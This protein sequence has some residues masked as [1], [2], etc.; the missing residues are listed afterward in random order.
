MIMYRRLTLIPLGVLVVIVYVAMQYIGF[1][2]LQLRPIDHT[3]LISNDAMLKANISIS[4]HG[5]YVYIAWYDHANG[6]IVLASS[7]DG[8][9]TYK[10]NTIEH[11]DNAVINGVVTKGSSVYIVWQSEVDGRYDVFLSRSSDGISFNTTNISNNRGDSTFPVMDVEGNMVY[12]AWIDSTDGDTDVLLRIS[13]DGGYTFS[14]TV[15]ISDNRGDSESVAVDAEG[16]SVYIAWHDN[17]DGTFKVMLR[18]SHDYGSTF[19][20]TIVLSDPSMDSGFV[21]M[22]AEGKDVYVA[23]MSDTGYESNSIY[24]RIS[25]DNGHSFNKAV[26]ISSDGI[27]VPLLTSDG[28]FIGLTYIDGR[29]LIFATI[30]SY[31]VVS[32]HDIGIDTDANAITKLVVDIDGYTIGMLVYIDGKDI[33]KV[34]YIRGDHINGFTGRSIA[35]ANADDLS[36]ALRGNTVY[37]AWSSKVCVGDCSNVKIGYHLIVG[38]EEGF[39]EHKLT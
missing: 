35:Y 17:S 20:D 29:G 28:A 13:N 18:T 22:V 15:N 4:V 32:S 36:I 33:G 16:S 38:D 10:S 34:V 7:R 5:P 25:N 30:A 3:S 1:G 37:M 23:W 19:S 12:I 11:V 8:G 26:L 2:V 31:G 27:S 9:N 24:L 21:S 6:S 14:E 39:R